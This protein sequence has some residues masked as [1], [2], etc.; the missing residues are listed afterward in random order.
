MPC[1]GCS[2]CM[3]WIPIK[4]N[5]TT[6]FDLWLKVY[7]MSMMHAENHWN[8][9]FLFGENTKLTSGNFEPWKSWKYNQL[10]GLGPGHS[11]L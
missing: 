1:S 7:S 11:C 9:L 3:E 10:W 2:P 6:C 5:H 4:T 8:T